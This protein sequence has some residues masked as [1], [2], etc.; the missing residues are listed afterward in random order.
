MLIEEVRKNLAIISY[1]FAQY[2]L[3]LPDM[4]VY[5]SAPFHAQ[6]PK[7]FKFMPT[8]H[9]NDIDVH[10]PNKDAFGAIASAIGIERHRLKNYEG[11]T[12]KLAIPGVTV[13]VEVTHRIPTDFEETFERDAIDIGVGMQVLTAKH[14]YDC[15]LDFGRPQDQ[16]RTAKVDPRDFEL[17]L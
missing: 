4:R 13:P 10:I 8:D 9:P 5:G 12:V 7:H 2:G 17:T 14:V 11:D 6:P 3:Y 1:H 15:W 16:R